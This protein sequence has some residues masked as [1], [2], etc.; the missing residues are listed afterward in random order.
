M[1]E[2][3]RETAELKAVIRMAH[4]A[5]KDLKACLKEAR[6]VRDELKTA[7]AER[8]E[9]RLNDAVEA[10]LVELDKSIET[11]IED[12]TQKV[13][14]RFDTIAD[15]LLGEDRKSTRLGKPNLTNLAQ[16]KRR[17]DGRGA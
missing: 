2:I 8:V 7:A 14:A 1:S 10:G 17:R 6:E 13:Y 4:E 3:T 5:I 9:G 15:I 16:A 12:S 11:A